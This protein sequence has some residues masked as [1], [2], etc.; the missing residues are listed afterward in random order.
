FPMLLGVLLVIGGAVLAIQAAV[1]KSGGSKAIAWPDRNGW[2]L[3]LIAMASLVFY[4]AISQALGFVISA[5]IFVPWFIRHFG[6]YSYWVAGS[7]AL[8]IAAFIYLVFIR[9]L[10]LTLPIGPLSFLG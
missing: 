5:L 2:K 3:L 1:A 4:V 9:L 6:R 7:C 10:Q 8:G